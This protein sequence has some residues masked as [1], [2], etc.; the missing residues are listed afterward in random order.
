M[1]VQPKPQVPSVSLAELDQA[2]DSGA[3]NASEIVEP[4]VGLVFSRQQYDSHVTDI[5]LAERL[6]L[7][8]L[9]PEAR[10]SWMQTFTGRR[11][12]PYAPQVDDVCIEDIAHALS[13]LCRYGGHCLR[14]FSVAE[15]SI[16]V[17][18]WLKAQGYDARMQMHGLLHDATEAYL[19]DMPRPIKKYLRGY[20]EL[21]ASLWSVIAVA[22]GM[23]AELP[24]PVKAADDAVLM[25]E[26]NQNMR[27]T[28]ELWTINVAP[29]DVTLQCA[30]PGVVEFWFLERFK[31]I[32]ACYS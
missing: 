32:N 9:P 12:Y 13:M 18:D 4:A 29:A 25:A 16:L 17:A 26:R 30:D 24:E 31:E 15:H 2:L 20:N 21:E 22:F 7:A 3:A 19:V 5:R 27:L 23:D 10:E 14:F 11:F 8:S 28:P 1:M 6:K